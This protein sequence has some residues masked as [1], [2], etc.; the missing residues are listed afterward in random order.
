MSEYIVDPATVRRSVQPM[1][2]HD[3][4]AWRGLPAIR[5]ETLIAAFGAAAKHEHAALG[6][7]P[8]DRYILDVESRARGLAV[9]ARA[10]EVVLIEALA[11]P[12]FSAMAGLGEPTKILPHEILSPGVYV[13]E[14]LYAPRGLVLGVAQP[15]QKEQPWSISRA[16]GIKPLAGA[17]EF[18]PELYQAFE[19]RKV[20]SQR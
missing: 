1:L 13:H 17:D 14:Y 2:D 7:Y 19:A 16:R 6:W 8:A 10:G 5:V 9:Y 3:L 15:F 18:G 12:P 4:A 11:P 20:W